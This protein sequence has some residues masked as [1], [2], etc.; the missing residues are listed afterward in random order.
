M[1]NTDVVM[2]GIDSPSTWMVFNA[3][4][5]AVGVDQ[6]VIED[7]VSGR[8]RLGAR[9]RQFGWLRVAGQV[10]FRLVLIPILRRRSTRRCREIRQRAGL[11]ATPPDRRRITRVPSINDPVARVA[12]EALA[13]TVVVVAGTRIIAGS[14]LGAIPA[15]FLNLHAGIT[16]HY[17]GV[18]GGYWA[19]ASGDATH[20]GVTVHVVDQGVDTGDIIAQARIAPTDRDTFVTYPLLQLDSGLP[21]LI[22]AVRAAL[23]DRLQR[24]A[25][26]GPSRQWYHPTAGEYLM[27]WLRRGVR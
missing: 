13:P 17:R 19:L 8:A 21:L 11:N 6:A 1:T 14:V 5:R 27:T 10:A 7:R 25:P 4:D 24:S 15:T 16:P 3:L 12:L 23:E 22:D 20:C 2:I 9:A 18:H 26:A